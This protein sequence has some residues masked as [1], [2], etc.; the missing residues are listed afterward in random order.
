MT[1]P[2]IRQLRDIGAHVP[3]YR[4]AWAE[5][6]LSLEGI[7]SL[8]QL[9]ET[10][11]RSLLQAGVTGRLDTRFVVQ[12]LKQEGTSGSTGE[13]M[14]I[15]LDASS[16]RRRRWRFLR[17]LVAAG[18]RPG[19][20]MLISTHRRSRALTLL[21][22]TYEDLRLRETD[23]VAR[24][25]EFRPAVLY[26]PLR[27]LMSIGERLPA[28]GHRH[29][30][31]ILISTAEKLAQHDQR[32]L[33]E[34]FG[35]EAFDFYGMTEMGLFA[36]RHPAQSHY[37]TVCD[38]VHAEYLPSAADPALERLLVTSIRPCPMPLVRYDT[39]DL[40][41]RD[42][43]L[44]GAPILEFVGREID[45]VLL[46][47]GQ[48]VSPYRLTLA[49]ETVPDVERFQIVQQADLTVEV[50]VRTCAHDPAAVL[51]NARRAIA[52]V[53]GEEI[54]VRAVCMREQPGSLTEKFHPVRSHARAVA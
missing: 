42:H 28:T 36:W 15:H 35:T 31:R 39:G 9:P 25:Q 37:R 46:Q 38:E 52:A 54:G 10:S 26:G 29:R 2:T 8:Q 7:E 49:M 34:M 12:R 24:Y 21:R 41:R 4:A 13:P 3:F 32:S 14:S 19:D 23:L 44:P 11:K 51:E 48:R 1:A 22:W 53:T 40:V 43:S 18:Y 5:A 33:R 6:G 20:R 47:D 50:A 27:A 16:L 45:G 17:A 30:P